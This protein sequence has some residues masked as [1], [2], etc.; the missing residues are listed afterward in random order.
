VAPKAPDDA[1]LLVLHGRVVADAAS[2]G[3]VSP[4]VRGR[5]D[6]IEVRAGDVVKRGD[7]VIALTAPE[8]IEAAAALRSAQRQ[9]KPARARAR[10]LRKLR[11]QGLAAS[12]AAYEIDQQVAALEAGVAQATAA[13]RAAGQ[14]PSDAAQLLKRGQ[15]TLTSP[16][17]G[18]VRRLKVRLGEVRGPDDG[19]LV[20]IA[21][22]GAARIEVRLPRP[23]PPGA[24][25]V[26]HGLSGA[27]VP[28]VPTPTATA[29]ALNEAGVLAWF[30]PIDAQTTLPDGLRGE[31]RLTVQGADVYEVPRAS[32]V[33][34]GGQAR[35]A[36]RRAEAVV[37]VEVQV[38]SG[39]GASALVR[40]AL[41]PSDSVAADARRVRVQTPIPATPAGA[42][43]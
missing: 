13:L 43:P 26:F 16:V 14:A 31:I 10:A 23:L 25:L 39:A 7:P 18:V 20:E 19:P 11:A 37:W 33:V 38:L 30:S 4:L 24:V 35:V 41:K 27:P 15:I 32:V 3:V 8:L 21:G 22:V 29:A 34:E 17:D 40:G 12:A 1:T 42:A 2:R 9:L 28:L 6:A 5:V 36:V